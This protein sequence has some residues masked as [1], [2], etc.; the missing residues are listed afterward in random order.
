MSI[1][2]VNSTYSSSCYTA[3]TVVG[4]KTGVFVS[5]S[6]TLALKIGKLTETTRSAAINV[7]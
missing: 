6:Q 7:C 2:S 4:S 3:K 5:D 1:I